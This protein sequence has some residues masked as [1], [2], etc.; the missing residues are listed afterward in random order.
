[1]SDK[2]QLIRYMYEHDFSFEEI[3]SYRI[4]YYE[5]LC[6]LQK[7]YLK[8]KN[9]FYLEEYQY[10][11]AKIEIEENKALIISDLHLGS[12]Y[13]NLEYI[14]EIERILEQENIRIVLNG[15]DLG[16]GMICPD[17]DYK[18]LMKQ[19]NHIL[20]VYPEKIGVTHYLTLGNHDKKYQSG[21][22][23]EKRYYHFRRWRWIFQFKE[24]F[25]FFKTS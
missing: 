10:H 5:M 25:N 11:C 19:I 4:S 21:G 16:D 22:T 3:L 8:T 15:G 6:F 23:R 2:F 1:M 12:K 13:E 24:S 20:D 14:K 18:S 7:E 9:P 17:S